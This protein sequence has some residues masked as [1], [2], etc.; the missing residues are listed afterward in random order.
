MALENLKSR[1]E[2]MTA[3]FNRDAL[4]TQALLKAEEERKTK[5]SILEVKIKFYKGHP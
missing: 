3:E 5:M 2:T 1:L 4:K